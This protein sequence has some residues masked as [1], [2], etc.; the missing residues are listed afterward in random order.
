MCGARPDD[1][2]LA[3][4]ALSTRG[5]PPHA[6]SYMTTVRSGATLKKLLCFKHLTM[7]VETPRTS[8]TRR[9]SRVILWGWLITAGK[10]MIIAVKNEPKL[11]ALVSAANHFIARARQQ[12]MTIHVHTDLKAGSR[13]AL[14]QDLDREP[15]L[16]LVF[17]GHGEREP[18]PG[19]RLD[20][21]TA[22]LGPADYRRLRRV[23]IAL[24]CHAIVVLGPAVR[25]ARGTILGFTE[26]LFL[27]SDSHA[28]LVTSCL[29][30]L[31][32]SL[33]DTEKNTVQHAAEAGR[34]AFRNAA[35]EL[36]RSRNLVLSGFMEE[37]AN[38]LCVLG[39]SK[40]T[41]REAVP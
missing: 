20:D 7:M 19:L 4:P 14:E 1:R 32:S 35:E 18:P 29:T 25:K 24:S 34:Q 22:F 9:A 26:E 27:F 15:S 38:R 37:N 8:F 39:R 5:V 30:Q 21:Q 6:S 28:D 2:T 3:S 16:A 13:S 17:F 40:R 10:D 12:E 41:I 31:L 11:R 36:V 23:I 33:L